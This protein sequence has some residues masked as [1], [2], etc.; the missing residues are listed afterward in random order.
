MSASREKKMRQQTQNSASAQTANSKKKNNKTILYS[1][2]A[3]V[4]VALVAFFTLLNTNFFEAHA[5]VATVGNRKLTA[6]E[7]NYWL[8]DTYNQEQSNSGFTA[9]VDTSIA[10]SDQ[11]CLEEGYETWYDYML[12]LALETAAKTYA[13][14]DEA[15]AAGFAV[16]E[17]AQASVDSQIQMLEMYAPLYGYSDANSYLTAVYGKGC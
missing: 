6:A 7:M 3:I 11:A 15:M 1:I 10:L 12:K 13:V 5:K 8:M 17:T 16:S 14:Y 4:V 9:L 2:I